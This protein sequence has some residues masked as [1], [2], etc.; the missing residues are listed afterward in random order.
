[1]KIE[2]R[3][4]DRVQIKIGDYII[5]TDVNG[6]TAKGN[7]VYV[8]NDCVGV[9]PTHE[10]TIILVE[11]KNIW[12]TAKSPLRY[13]DKAIVEVTKEMTFDSCHHLQ[14][15]IG[16]C[17]RLHGHTYKLQVTFRGTCDDIGMVI[18]FKI[19]KKLIKEKLLSMYDHYNLD[20]KMTFNT[21]AENMVVFFYDVISMM[22]KDSNVNVASVKLWETPTSFAEFKGEVIM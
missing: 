17:A 21:T 6:N 19:I 11:D 12:A 4:E 1:M 2:E 9:K 7:V 14:Q 22:L 18:D 20:D 16:D 15:Y 5:Y 3:I 10:N 13:S 8:K